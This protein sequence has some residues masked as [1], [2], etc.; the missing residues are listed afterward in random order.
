MSL[1]IRRLIGLAERCVFGKQSLDSLHCGP[2][3][4]GE[5]V[6]ITCRA[7]LIPKLRGQFAE[8]LCE[9]YLEH[10]RI[11]TPPTC[12]GLWYGYRLAPPRVFSAAWY[13]S[14]GAPE[15]L[16][17]HHASE[18]IGARICLRSPPTR[19]DRHDRR[20]ADLSLLRHPEVQRFPGSTG[21]L[22]CCPSPTPFGLGLGTD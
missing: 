4:S 1:P 22:T 13:G 10:L 19:L 15:G 8:F 17:P 21:I 11:F 9:G 16:F 14:V 3:R 20:P 18:L 2:A 12:V 6:P 7:P 5:Q